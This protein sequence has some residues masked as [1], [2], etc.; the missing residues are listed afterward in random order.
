MDCSVNLI[1]NK[2]G[3]PISINIGKTSDPSK[4][5]LSEVKKMLNILNKNT[6]DKIVS[7]IPKIDEVKDINIADFN[8]SLAGVYTPAELIN[9]VP[10][11]S[12]TLAKL[13][14]GEHKDKAIVISG[15]APNNIKT[16]YVNGFIFLNFNFMFENENKAIALFE[17]ALYLSE[18]EKYNE[19]INLLLSEKTSTEDKVKLISTAFNKDSYN[20]FDIELI[21]GIYNSEQI[22]KYQE[23]TPIDII[24]KRDP[25]NVFIN[26][27]NKDFYVTNRE[28]NYL[29]NQV[30]RIENVKQGDLI[31]VKYSGNKTKYEVFYDYYQ[32]ADGRVFVKTFSDGPSLNR[33]VLDGNEVTI[34][35]HTSEEINISKKSNDGVKIKL[36][37]KGFYTEFESVYKLIKDVAVEADGNKVKS[38]SGSIIKFEDGKE[39]NIKD[40]KEI[41]TNISNVKFN[42]YEKEVPLELLEE[43]TRFNF[44]TIAINSK[45]LIKQGDT[46]IE[47]LIK[48]IG[49]GFKNKEVIYITSENNALVSGS[50]SLAAI[51]YVFNNI[52]DLHKPEDITLINGLIDNI[53]KEN[54]IQEFLENKS[55]RLRESKFSVEQI[56]KTTSFYKGD[57]IADKTS[58]VVRYYTVIEDSKNSLLLYSVF[59]SKPEYVERNKSEFI[60]KLLFS[61]IPINQNFAINNILK[62]RFK[63]S[64]D[65]TMESNEHNI[66]Y[67]I[68]VIQSKEGFI[69]VVPKDEVTDGTNITESYKDILK[70]RFK[71]DK[72]GAKL[73]AFKRKENR[74]LDEKLTDPNEADRYVKDSLN[75]IHHKLKNENDLSSIMNNLIPGSF[76]T[77]RENAKSFIVEKVMEDSLLLSYYH[78]TDKKV[79]D[80]NGLEYVISE[81]FLLTKEQILNMNNKF[82]ASLFVPKWA[83][84]INKQINSTLIKTDTVVNSK[85]SVYSNQDMPEI[86]IAFSQFL[87]NQYDIKTNIID[88]KDLSKFAGLD[89]EES[90]AFI[91]N[92]EIYINTDLASIEEPLHELLHLVLMT[93][94]HKDPNT[95]YTLVNS[96]STHPMFKY[97]AEVYSG[98]IMTEK[99]EETF[100]KL[101]SQTFR[102]KIMVDGIL[103]TDTFNDAVNSSISELLQLSGDISGQNTFDLLGRSLGEILSTFGNTLL[104]NEEGLIDKNSVALMLEVSGTI[105][106]LINNGNLKEECY[107]M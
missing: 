36:T 33:R 107:G 61:Q 48:G 90:A 64:D 78:Y 94:K 89:V 87:S 4:I 12:K 86:I 79:N 54:S 101:I 69:K 49:Q 44:K 23:D 7:L 47:A 63:I 11:Y 19:N 8:E 105:K 31:S 53:Y 52:K 75:T 104:G 10:K 26:K 28:R 66:P 21:L 37:G 5:K 91:Y 99:L 102:K 82:P 9:S 65:P 84:E 106:Q 85:V 58:N 55:S 74:K 43:L 6:L 72:I 46:F 17:T 97:V 30:A 35:K 68:K 67:E 32:G 96:I 103:N 80:I 76:I 38:I 14:L 92:G 40:I 13:K 77:F 71:K 98:E 39:K 59:N 93:L 22:Q 18:P 16:Q 34:R 45:V 24:N 25:V 3:E 83:T 100:V 1:I 41:T 56:N 81:K 15:F 20:E 73:F 27:F 88:N 29:Q 70:S 60:G 62:N 57:I 2:D 42:R 50:V 95:Y 51:K